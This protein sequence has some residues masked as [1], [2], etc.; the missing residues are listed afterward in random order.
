MKLETKNLKGLSKEAVEDIEATIEAGAEE[1]VVKQ[2]ME[3][4]YLGYDY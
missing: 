2:T 1:E 3:S 4:Y